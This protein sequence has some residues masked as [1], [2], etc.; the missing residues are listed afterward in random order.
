MQL[1]KTT[2][3][4][5][6]G[7]GL[8]LGHGLKLPWTRLSRLGLDIGLWTCLFGDLGLDLRPLS[9]CYDLESSTYPTSPAPVMSD[10]RDGPGL[11]RV[12]R[13]DVDLDIDLSVLTLLP[14]FSNC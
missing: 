3:D 5:A 7:I 9:T 14:S 11:A 13:P 8:G 1:H 12:A 6:W 2:A 4:L 10:R